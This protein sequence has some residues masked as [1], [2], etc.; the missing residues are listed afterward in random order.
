MFNQM[1]IEQNSNKNMPRK[2]YPIIPT[3]F[4]FHENSLNSNII[5]FKV[6]A[7]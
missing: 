6:H 5:A 4:Y 7:Y 3:I 2:F 1:H